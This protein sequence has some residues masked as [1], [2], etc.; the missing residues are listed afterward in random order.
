MRIDDYLSTVGAIKR[1]TIAKQLCQNGLVTVDGRVV[2]AAYPV[3]VAEI[4]AIK[5][6]RPQSGE[7]LEV[8]SGSV[9]KDQ[10]G[11]YYKVLSGD[12]SD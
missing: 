12:S 4:I 11:N 7:V 6:S 9:P 2:K 10:R 8:P 1:R 5:G 3:K